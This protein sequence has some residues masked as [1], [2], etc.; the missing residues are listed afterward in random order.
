MLAELRGK[1]LDLSA[2][3]RRFTR[4]E[5]A[6]IEMPVLVVS[7]QESPA[8]LRRVADRLSARLPDVRMARVA[9]GHFIDPAAPPVLAFIDRYAAT[10]S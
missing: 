3:P 2:G 9:G 1:G 5:L 10:A 4:D 6:A 8:P 7:A